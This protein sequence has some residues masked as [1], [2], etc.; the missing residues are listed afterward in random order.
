MQRY[1]CPDCL[2]ECDSLESLSVHRELFCRGQRLAI[3]PA[4]TEHYDNENE[5]AARGAEYDRLGA[6]Y[7]AAL[8]ALECD[9]NAVPLCELT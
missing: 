6:E 8:F 5:R 4:S 3:T 2:G 1:Q 9:H 7:L